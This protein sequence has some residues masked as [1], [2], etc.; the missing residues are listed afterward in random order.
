MIGTQYNVL[1]YRNY[2][3]MAC[4]KC[5]GINNEETRSLQTIKDIRGNSR[6]RIKSDAS[7]ATTA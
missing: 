7:G 3:I 6:V 4:N 2:T 1:P 5:T